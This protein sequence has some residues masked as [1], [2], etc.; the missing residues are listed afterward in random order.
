[1]RDRGLFFG[2]DFELVCT[3]PQSAVTDL[4]ADLSVGLSVIGETTADASVTL[5]GSPLPD[6]GYTH[7]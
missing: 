3:V 1:L 7:G 2:E 6:E 5:E 4:Q